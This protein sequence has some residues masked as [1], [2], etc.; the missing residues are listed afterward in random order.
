MY[1]P[2]ETVTD[3]SL[4]EQIMRVNYLGAVYCTHYALPYLKASKGLIDLFCS[5]GTLALSS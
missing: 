2:F 5:E 3:L 4:F 1:A